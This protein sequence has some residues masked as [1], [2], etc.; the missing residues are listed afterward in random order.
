MKVKK[1]KKQISLIERV[2]RFFFKSKRISKGNNFDLWSK[3]DSIKV[4]A[5]EEIN[6]NID[7]K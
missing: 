6:K 5:K 2:K 7:K 3:N 1:N 4:S